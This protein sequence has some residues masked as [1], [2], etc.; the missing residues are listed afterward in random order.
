M[1]LRKKK[2]RISWRK[3]LDVE[4]HNLYLH[5]ILRAIKSRKTKGQEK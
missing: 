5:I 2:E 4:F 3:L 1:D